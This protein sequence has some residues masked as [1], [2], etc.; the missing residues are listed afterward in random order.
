L[1]F[2][3]LK[4]TSIGGAFPFSM[5]VVRVLVWLVN[6]RFP[7]AGEEEV[8]MEIPDL[9]ADRDAYCAES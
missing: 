3:G 8:L 2:L 5:R 6:V 9:D 7:F 1:S 4:T